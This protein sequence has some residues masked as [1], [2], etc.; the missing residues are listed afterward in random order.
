MSII[1]TFI[2]IDSRSYRMGQIFNDYERDMKQYTSTWSFLIT[3][4]YASFT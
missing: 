3:E 2:A 4:P 1:L